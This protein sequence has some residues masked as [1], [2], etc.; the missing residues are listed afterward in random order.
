MS[1]QETYRSL[2]NLPKV[3][4]EIQ[5]NYKQQTKEKMTCPEN[6]KGN[7]V[8]LNLK[9]RDIDEEAQKAFDKILRRP[10]SKK[11]MKAIKILDSLSEGDEMIIAEM[12]KDAGVSEDD[13][14]TFTPED[15]EA[16]KQRI[17]GIIE[18][19]ILKEEE[20]IRQEEEKRREEEEKRKRLEA[21]R[22]RDTVAPCY[23]SGCQVHSITPKGN[24]LEHYN[25]TSI[26]NMGDAYKLARDLIMKHGG[27]KNW[28]SV[29]MYKYRLVHRNMSGDVIKIYH[30]DEEGKVDS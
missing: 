26:N 15:I 11:Y 3:Q 27:T 21:D 24:I 7:K 19:E 12:K 10:R 1:M 4:L 2:G 13:D 23:I 16:F 9:E 20:R 25:A 14:L 5:K 29:E 30:M 8:E 22:L 18:E 17:Q 6:I 28:S